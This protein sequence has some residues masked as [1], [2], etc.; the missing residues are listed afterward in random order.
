MRADNRVAATAYQAGKFWETI[1]HEFADYLWAGALTNL[2][3]E[4]FNRRFA[5]P[6]PCSRQVYCA[7]LHLYFHQLLERDRSDFLKT[8][9][10]PSAGGTADQEMI[11]GRPMSLDF[12][13]SVDEAF[14]LREAWAL[15]GKSGEPAIIV[16]LGAGYGRLAYVCR[17]LFPSCTYVILDLPE[18]LICS[19][20]WLSRVFPGEVVPYESARDIEAFTPDILGSGKIWTLGAHHIERIAAKSVDAFVNIYSFAEMPKASIDTYFRH[21]DRITSGIF[22]TKQRALETNLEDS[23]VI[24]SDTYQ[25]RDHWRRL[26][27]RTSR[28]Y[29]SFF[30]EAYAIDEPAS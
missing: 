29:G 22:F 11:D 1:N 6:D 17:S 13:Q 15:A 7:L 19:S 3:N 12:L 27:H 25:I 8:A 23:V 14:C 20:S 10:E 21:I 16:E 28:L 2:R 5:G 4:Y 18:A 30:E 26:F 24:S 9:Y